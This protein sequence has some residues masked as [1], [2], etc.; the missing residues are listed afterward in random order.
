[1]LC[2]VIYVRSEVATCGGVDCENLQPTPFEIRGRPGN[3]TARFNSHIGMEC[4][5]AE[6]DE[7]WQILT[8]MFFL[9]ID[10][11]FI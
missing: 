2:T 1:M 8:T 4:F 9:N 7:L 11:K 6:L 5:L 10:L 3:T